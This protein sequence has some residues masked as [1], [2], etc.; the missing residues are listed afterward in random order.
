MTSRYKP[1]SE[2]LG[3]P[4]SRDGTMNLRASRLNKLNWGKR[5]LWTN[6]YVTKQIRAF[7][8]I[9]PNIGAVTAKTTTAKAVRTSAI[10][11][12]QHQ[13]HQTQNNTKLATT[14]TTT[15]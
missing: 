5:L 8:K 3:S 11:A 1:L 10:A 15:A 2:S 13:Q 4:F 9:G 6:Y 7:S 12:T 14:A